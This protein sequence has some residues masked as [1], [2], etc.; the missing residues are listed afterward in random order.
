MIALAAMA[1]PPRHLPLGRTG[2]ER[3]LEDRQRRLA[4]Q[5]AVRDL[6]LSA[7]FPAA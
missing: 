5:E 7:D 1:D 3:I 4:E 6:A 2:F